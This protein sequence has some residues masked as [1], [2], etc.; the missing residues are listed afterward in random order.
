MIRVKYREYNRER[1][2]YDIVDGEFIAWGIETNTNNKINTVA[3]I[4]TS[5]GFLNTVRIELITNYYN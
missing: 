4:K 2:E 5:D 1:D 3:I